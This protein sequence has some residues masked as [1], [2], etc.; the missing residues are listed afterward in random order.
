[1]KYAWVE[2]NV[3]RDIAPGDPSLFYTPQVAQLYSTI[4]DDYVERDAVLVNGA[5]V[6]IERPSELDE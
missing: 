1:M 4:V 6:N 2:N 3:I 5:W